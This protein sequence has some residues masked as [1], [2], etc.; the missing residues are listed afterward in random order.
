M[1]RTYFLGAKTLFIRDS[2]SVGEYGVS[3]L[4]SDAPYLLPSFAIACPLRMGGLLVDSEVTTILVV[5]RGL[6]RDGIEV[7]PGDW[8]FER[9]KSGSL[10]SIV[11][12]VIPYL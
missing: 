3:G 10:I 5:A 7:C 6:T 11:W 1:R 9:Q 2:R 8:D 12:L 4:N